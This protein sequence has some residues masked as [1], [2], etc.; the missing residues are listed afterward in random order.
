MVSKEGLKKWLTKFKTK[1]WFFTKIQSSYTETLFG[2][3]YF[4]HI[5]KNIIKI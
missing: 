2:F 5:L 4:L 3:L 1:K